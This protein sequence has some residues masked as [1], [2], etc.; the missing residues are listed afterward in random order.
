LQHLVQGTPSDA[1]RAARHYQRPGNAGP[2][3]LSNAQH[4]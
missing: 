4:E 1:A 3:P 2:G